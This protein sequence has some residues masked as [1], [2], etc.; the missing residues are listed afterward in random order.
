MV[1]ERL[2]CSKKRF[3]AL[4]CCAYAATH[5]SVTN[6]TIKGLSKRTVEDSGEGPWAN[7]RKVL[8][9]TENVISTNRRFRRERLCRNLR[10]DKETTLLFFS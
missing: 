5:S 4:K 3:D 1:E 9:K 7:Y 10:A 8:D 6:L 2:D